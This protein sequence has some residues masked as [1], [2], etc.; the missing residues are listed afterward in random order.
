MPQFILYDL[1]VT[2]STGLGVG[3]EGRSFL[4]LPSPS[5]HSNVHK[6]MLHQSALRLSGNSGLD[7]T[8]IGEQ[9]KH[10]PLP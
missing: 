10:G 1:R 7:G 3:T 8:L 5:I 9:Q 2:A 6:S 4:E